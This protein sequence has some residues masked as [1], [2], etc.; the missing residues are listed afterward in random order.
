MKVKAQRGQYLLAVGVGRYNWYQ[1]QT[2]G[3]MPVW[4]LFSKGGRH[5]AMCQ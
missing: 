5:E 1:S 3:D 4:R 2:L